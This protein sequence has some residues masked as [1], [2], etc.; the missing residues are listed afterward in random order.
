MRP[1]AS[2]RARG[3]RSEPPLASLCRPVFVVPIVWLKPGTVQRM[4]GR[5][6]PPGEAGIG[7]RQ[8]E[9]APPVAGSLQL[10][11]V[12]VVA[13]GSGEGRIVEADNRQQGVV[14]AQEGAP[15]QGVKRVVQ[16]VAQLDAI[17]GAGDR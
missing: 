11:N 12:H 10:G 4:D 16:L 17:E 3:E 9:S 6:G 13:E 1:W 15:V 5:R 2:L 7:K 14:P 8:L